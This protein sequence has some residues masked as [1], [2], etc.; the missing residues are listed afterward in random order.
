MVIANMVYQSPLCR[1]SVA[2][3]ERFE[4]FAMLQYCLNGRVAIQTL[5]VEQHVVIRT[6]TVKEIGKE[7]VFGF[8]D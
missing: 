2:S 1:G 5:I 7:G 4:N 3:H 6:V 8:L